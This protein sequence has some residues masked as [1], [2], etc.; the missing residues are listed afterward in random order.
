M[1]SVITGGRESLSES[2][3]G[4]ALVYRPGEASEHTVC[5][6]LCMCACVAVC[7]CLCMYVCLFGRIRVSCVCVVWP[8]A[9]AYVMYLCCARRRLLGVNAC[10]DLQASPKLSIVKRRSDCRLSAGTSTARRMALH[11]TA[12]GG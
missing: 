8:Y 5:V 1:V 9:C 3:A 2:D 6:R 7:V 10:D 4:R 12:S 11:L